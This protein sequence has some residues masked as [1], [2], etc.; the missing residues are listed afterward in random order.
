MLG[1]AYGLALAGAVVQLLALRVVA[2][3]LHSTTMRLRTALVTFV[4]GLTARMVEYREVEIDVQISDAATIT[5]TA[6]VTM[7]APHVSG[8]G[9]VGGP[10]LTEAQRLR[11]AEDRI[12]GLGD[13]IQNL[14]NSLRELGERQAEQSRSFVESLET[15]RA[16]TRTELEHAST[17]L[18]HERLAESAQ[19]LGLVLLAAST[20]A[21]L[22]G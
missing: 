7:P 11:I 9:Y 4:D 6:I 17:P 2:R 22:F 3:R 8:K 20:A 14:D 10:Q 15:L 19:A 5:A 21:A 13:Q 16:E 1:L 12:V 18:P